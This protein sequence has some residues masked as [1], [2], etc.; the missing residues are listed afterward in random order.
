MYCSWQCP[1][2]GV[3]I[4]VCEC[5]AAGGGSGYA[6]TWVQGKNNKLELAKAWQQP[7]PQT[8]SLSSDSLMLII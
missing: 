6:H 5:I 3:P 8:I 2:V 7:T 4:C 1:G